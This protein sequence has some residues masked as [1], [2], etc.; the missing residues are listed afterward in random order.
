MKNIIESNPN[1][2]LNTIFP[3]SCAFGVNKEFFLIIKDGLDSI[4]KDEITKIGPF[5]V[6][7]KKE[8]KEFEVFWRDFNK[9]LL[10]LLLSFKL[11]NIKLPKF[12]FFEILLFILT[13]LDQFVVFFHSS[14]IL[15]QFIKKKGFKPK[16]K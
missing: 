3:S 13:N 4:C 9:K 8:L 14:H 7:R 10:S 5:Y 6:F 15:S 12:V 16:K 11:S 2:F 1:H